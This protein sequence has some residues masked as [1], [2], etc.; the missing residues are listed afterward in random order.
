MAKTALKSLFQIPLNPLKLTLNP[1]HLPLKNPFAKPGSLRCR[2]LET[3]AKAQ[4]QKE[5]LDL[6]FPAENVSFCQAK[7]IWDFTAD[8]V[9]TRCYKKKG[10]SYPL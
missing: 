3:G 6:D 8:G 9:A 7:T 2:D 1:I 5:W 4:S 10:L